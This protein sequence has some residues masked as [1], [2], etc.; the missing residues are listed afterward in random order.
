MPVN[1]YEK[2]REQSVMTMT[3]GEML[4]KLYDEI[5]KQLSGA[6]I[7]IE[8]KDYPK[9][10]KCLQKSQKVLNHLKTTL[11]FKYDVS[12]NLSALYDFFIQQTVVANIHKDPKP[13]EEIIPMVEELKEAF[14]E[15][16]RRARVQ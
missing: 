2:Y 3:N 6:V 9:T 7:Y 10:N 8:Q 16:E 11:N 14:A 5:V 12:N 13:I 15:A 4:L 1:P